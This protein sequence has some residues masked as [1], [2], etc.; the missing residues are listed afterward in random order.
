MTE[1][2]KDFGEMTEGKLKRQKNDE[3]VAMGLD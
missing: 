3:R 1:G 2:L